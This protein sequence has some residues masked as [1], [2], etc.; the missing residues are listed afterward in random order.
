MALAGQYNITLD[1]GATYSQLVTWKNSSGT[2]IDLTGWTARMQVRPLV[3]SATSLIELTT[4]N[5]RISLGGA[6]GTITLT[7]SATDTD[8]LPVGTYRYDLELVDGSTVER[9]LMGSFTVRG[10]ATR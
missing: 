7:I 5:G 1:Q 9:L 4:E 8:D 6:A 10:E 2:L 3:K